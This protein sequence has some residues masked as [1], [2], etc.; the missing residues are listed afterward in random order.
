MTMMDYNPRVWRSTRMIRGYTYSLKYHYD[1]VLKRLKEVDC[2][3]V[4]RRFYN[5]P[6][7]WKGKPAY[8]WIKLKEPIPL[9]DAMECGLIPEFNTR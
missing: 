8:G 3:I 6:S 9:W 7:T 4:D 1:I 2:R 5:Q